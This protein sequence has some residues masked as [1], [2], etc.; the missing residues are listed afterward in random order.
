MITYNKKYFDTSDPSKS[1]KIEY[2]VTEDLLTWFRTNINLYC[3]YGNDFGTHSIAP[4][5]TL[6]SMNNNSTI[7][8]GQMIYINDATTGAA[9]PL[10]AFIK[11]HVRT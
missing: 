1:L 7:V 5:T 2:G 8:Q 3:D 6:G 10:T 9:M 11:R 4:S